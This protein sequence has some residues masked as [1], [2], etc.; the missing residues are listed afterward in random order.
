MIKL[1]SKFVLTKQIND[2]KI[3]TL[4]QTKVNAILKTIKT[5]KALGLNFTG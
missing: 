4:Y 5:K 2:A 3:K 1:N